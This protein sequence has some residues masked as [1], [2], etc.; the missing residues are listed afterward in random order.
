VIQTRAA[1]LPEEKENPLSDAKIKELVRERDGYKCRDCGMSDE[2]H[3][4]KFD[5]TLEV[6]RLVPGVEYGQTWCVTLCCDCHKKKIR[7]TGDAFW[8]K[9][10]R[11]FG[12]NLYDT[13]DAKLYTLLERYSLARGIAQSEAL[14][15]IL[16]GH[17][18]DHDV[19]S[20][21]FLIPEAAMG[22][23]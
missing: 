19:D 16:D 17:F 22:I 12:F 7:K 20:D 18:R 14:L 4:E 21:N 11:W 6:H 15:A 5:Q 13:K 10:L 9:D 1:G 3:Q 23:S 2:D 8:C